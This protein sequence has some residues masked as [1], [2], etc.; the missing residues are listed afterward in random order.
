MVFVA[1]FMKNWY[2]KIVE[3]EHPVWAL[4]ETKQLYGHI[5]KEYKDCIPEK[6]PAD[7]FN[8]PSKIF[9]KLYAHTWD[10]RWQYAVMNSIN[11][12]IRAKSGREQSTTQDKWIAYLEKA[13][14][15]YDRFVATIPPTSA[16]A[17]ASANTGGRPSAGGNEKPTD[18]QEFW[19]F[20]PYEKEMA[21]VAKLM[22][23]IYL[24]KVNFVNTSFELF[25]LQETNLL[26]NMIIQSYAN[27][28]G[29]HP[30]GSDE[31]FKHS[32]DYRWQ[33]AVMSV[34]NSNSA[35]MKIKFRKERFDEWIKYLQRSFTYE[36]FTFNAFSMFVPYEKE[37]VFVAEFMKNMSPNYDAQKPNADDPVLKLKVTQELYNDILNS[38]NY[39][40]LLEERMIAPF[41]NRT[42]LIY[43]WQYALMSV[44]KDT[45]FHRNPKYPRTTIEYWIE[46]LQ[47]AYQLSQTAA[48]PALKA[49]GPGSAGGKQGLTTP[50]NAEATVVQ[51]PSGGGNAAANADIPK[52]PLPSASPPPSES[53]EDDVKSDAEESDADGAGPDIGTVP[54]TPADTNFTPENTPPPNRKAEND[55]PKSAPTYRTLKEKESAEDLVSGRHR[56]F[57]TARDRS[58][59]EVYNSNRGI[60]KPDSKDGPAADAAP[61]DGG[62]DGDAEAGAGQQTPTGSTS[63]TPRIN[64]KNR[65]D[66]R[67]SVKETETAE[68]ARSSRIRN[69]GKYTSVRRDDVY[70][71]RREK[72]EASTETKSETPRSPK[73]PRTENAIA[74]ALERK[75]GSSLI[76]RNKSTSKS[77]EVKDISLW[78]KRA[79]ERIKERVKNRKRSRTPAETQETPEEKSRRLLAKPKISPEEMRDKLYEDPK[80]KFRWEKY[81]A[82][83]TT[84]ARYMNL[85]INNQIHHFPGKSDRNDILDTNLLTAKLFY[86]INDALDDSEKPYDDLLQ[87]YDL[88]AQITDEYLIIDAM[89]GDAEKFDTVNTPEELDQCTPYPEWV[90]FLENIR[91]DVDDIQ[92]LLAMRLGS[93]LHTFPSDVS[94]MIYNLTRRLEALQ[95]W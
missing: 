88:S 93:E 20:R 29:E 89:D 39:D 72:E 25:G 63:E 90:S 71:Q 81:R 16:A 8:R 47:K 42:T 83:I 62:A 55:R 91:P 52:L 17:V 33:W 15:V 28:V 27:K 5:V 43:A 84:L 78:R 48:T 3:A 50:G 2:L 69:A 22:K 32:L 51:P 35:L 80:K 40:S 65:K 44:I 49:G 95:D 60:Q 37:V 6:R 41:T 1:L 45:I 57:E 19:V 11:D 67:R 18:I 4:S 94:P 9:E 14:Q 34:I 46:Y 59:S 66:T 82:K 7:T 61:A 12:F 21:F 10:F 85:L 76:A 24:K 36:N 77:V 58:R 86:R 38:K 53:S 26:Y 73:T 56:G 79:L 75:K 64:V 74:K 87:E 54:N 13:V 68:D 30:S 92:E 31:F 70:K 23:N